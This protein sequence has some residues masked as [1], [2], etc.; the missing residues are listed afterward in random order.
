M[1]KI[2]GLALNPLPLTQSGSANRS[3]NVPLNDITV[4]NSNYFK[5]KMQFFLILDLIAVFVAI[6]KVS[7]GFY[8]FLSF[9]LVITALICSCFFFFFSGRIGKCLVSTCH[10]V[11]TQYWQNLLDGVSACPKVQQERWCLI[12]GKW[13]LNP[14]WS[15]N[16]ITVNNSY[17]CL[18][19]DSK[20]VAKNKIR[21]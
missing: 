21:S 12:A 10:K 4:L 2:P 17:I 11:W 7:E 8:F 1:G 9:F 16:T 19:P 3:S 6:S 18:L 13:S 15:G 20:L 5:L 14:Y